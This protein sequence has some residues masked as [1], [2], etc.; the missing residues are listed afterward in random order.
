[1]FCHQHEQTAEGGMCTELDVCAKQHDVAAL[2]DLFIY[3]VKGLSQVALEGRKFGINELETGQFICKA[4]G[5]TLPNDEVDRE[6]YTEFIYEAVEKREALKEMVKAAGGRIDFGDGPATFEPGATS[7]TLMAQGEKVGILSDVGTY[8]DILSLHELLIDGIKGIV[9]CADHAA[10]L[11]KEDSHVYAFM[12]EGM[13][14]TLRNNL[15]IY[16]YIDL[17]LKCGEVKLRTI[18]LLVATDTDT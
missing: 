3:V 5:A 14:S 2:Q 16:D 12:Q 9:A 10:G 15:G 7:E 6:G 4:I 8:A 11:G 1:M 18:E 17:V 13:A